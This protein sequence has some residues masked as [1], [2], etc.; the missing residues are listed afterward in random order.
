MSLAGERLEHL[1]IGGGPAGSMAAVCLADAGCRVVLA[2]RERAAHAKVCGEFLSREAVQY[3]EQMDIEPCKLGAVPIEHVRM[4]VGRSVAEVALPFRALSL[5]RFV[6]DEAMLERAKA[7]GCAVRRGVEVTTLRRDGDGWRVGLRNGDS[8]QA[9]TVFLASGKHDLQAWGRGHGTQTDLVGFKLHWRLTPAQTASLRGVMELFL[10]PGGYGGMSLVEREGANLCL[11]VR[12]TRLRAVGGWEKL[13]EEIRRFDR[14]LNERLTGA[15]PRSERPLAI[16]PIP[17]GYLAETPS[18]T[19][20]VGDQAAVIPSF[21]GDGMSIALHSAALASG[22]YL[23]GKSADEYV[24]TLRAQLGGSMR[25]AT[26]L[27]R[28]MVTSAGRHLA[29]IGL[30]LIPQ[31]LRWIAASTRIAERDR[32]AWRGHARGND[33][34]GAAFQV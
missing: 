9:Q 21:T 18:V 14:R 24:G 33:P 12:R 31:G 19:W 6:L 4:T 25:L 10:F 15:E 27:S 5:S 23:S 20:C 32:V 2:E 17:Y 3:L 1:V 28:A 29:P 13:L 8:L 11:A 7:G 16:A 22:M 26:G 34:L 30:S